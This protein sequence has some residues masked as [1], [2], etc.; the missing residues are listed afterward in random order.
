MFD[1]FGVL[2]FL[3]I[4]VV[5]VVCWFV[6]VLRCVYFKA[7]LS[8]FVFCYL[9]LFGYICVLVLLDL[10]GFVF[11]FGVCVLLASFCWFDY[12]FVTGSDTLLN[13]W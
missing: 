8:C 6:S 13:A 12:V 10:R 2:F 3:C 4:I 7:F 1:Y 9:A 5:R 11:R